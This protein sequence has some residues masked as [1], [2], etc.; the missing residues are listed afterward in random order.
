LLLRVAFVISDF[1]TGEEQYLSFDVNEPGSYSVTYSLIPDTDIYSVNT[2]TVN[3]TMQL[4]TLTG[5]AGAEAF[6]PLTEAGAVLDYELTEAG[7]YY[8]KLTNL[9]I[10]GTAVVSIDK[11]E[12][13]VELLEE[14][15]PLYS[16]DNPAVITIGTPYFVDLLNI[17]NIS[18]LL[19]KLLLPDLCNRV[20]RSRGH[21]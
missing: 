20:Y 10:S 8:I 17:M 9:G 1:K 6:A 16:S 15:S 14:T 18:I 19:M 4:G 12:D 5:E 21:T 13:S 7:T 11:K 2:D 3:V